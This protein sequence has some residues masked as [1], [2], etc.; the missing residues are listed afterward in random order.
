MISEFRTFYLT[1]N[2]IQLNFKLHLKKEPS[3]PPADAWTRRFL[4]KKV[5]GLSHKHPSVLRAGPRSCRAAPQKNAISG[6]APEVTN[7]IAFQLIF[8]GIRPKV[9]P[10]N[11]IES[12]SLLPS[13]PSVVLQWRL[14]GIVPN[15]HAN[16][17]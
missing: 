10:I 2:A 13:P 5:G 6:L 15:F 11:P 7:L 1:G 4:P 16:K 9:Y 8:I 12:G 17:E 3:F 14:S